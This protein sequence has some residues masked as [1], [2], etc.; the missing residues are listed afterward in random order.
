MRHLLVALAGIVAVSA[1]ADDRAAKLGAL[2]QQFWEENL[3]LNPLQATYAG[4]R[5]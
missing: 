4:D 3:A 1:H 5:R 2:Y